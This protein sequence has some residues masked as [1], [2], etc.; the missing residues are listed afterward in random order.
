MSDS[1]SVIKSLAQEALATVK[2]AI[3]I[4]DARA[5][6]M[7]IVYMNQAFEQLTG[8]SES[9]VL[10]RNCRFL[11]GPETEPA[12]LTPIREALQSHK[13]AHAVLR[14]YRK[15][16]SLFINELYINPIRNAAGETTHFVG[17]QNSIEP[18][19]LASPL[20]EAHQRFATLSKREREVFHAITGGSTIK[21]F[22]RM[23]GLS[24]RTAEKYRYR[25]QE[26][27]GEKSLTMLVR[28]AIVLGT[29]F[30]EPRTH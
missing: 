25:M 20:R 23:Q 15:D 9:E 13:P 26:K 14:N 5:E 22:A 2:S 29:E 12:S 11:Q 21:D 6:D 24:P 4:T 10:G 18:P 16:G 8:Y 3:L 27:M 7:P 28:Y 19:K 30:N 17:C 1:L